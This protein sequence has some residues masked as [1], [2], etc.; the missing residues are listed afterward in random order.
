M[1]S[2]VVCVRALLGAV[3][4]ASS[5]GKLVG[6]NRLTSFAQSV[7][8][9]GLLPAWLVR[10]VALA[11]PVVELA[12]AALL[13]MPV[14][15]LWSAGLLVATGLLLVFA[16]G[17]VPA[18]R[19]GARVPCR[20]FGGSTA[21]LGARQL[22]RNLLLSAAALA[23]AAV[24]GPGASTTGTVGTAL[25]VAAGLL[26]GVLVVALDD[27]IELFRT[28]RPEEVV[29]VRPDSAPAPRRGALRPGPA[30]HSRSDQAAA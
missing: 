16:I 17:I 23:A 28:T 21:P 20:C 2:L 26:L 29:D 7:E 1:H 14:R 19:H 6:R 22:A 25:A 4:L 8:G 12:D 18:L 30:A 5:I 24:S 13:A 9:L 27:L 10:P 11:V 15:V 3:F